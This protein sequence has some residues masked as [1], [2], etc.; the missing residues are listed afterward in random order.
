MKR[1]LTLIATLLLVVGLSACGNK[2][3]PT[4]LEETLSV[5][6]T[7]DPFSLGGIEID[8]DSS[9]Q[10]IQET[11]PATEVEVLETYS[12]GSK[13]SLYSDGSIRNTSNIDNLPEVDKLT[14]AESLMLQ[15]IVATWDEQSTLSQDYLKANIT[16]DTFPSL[17]DTD[18]QRI[19]EKIQKDKPHSSEETEAYTTEE[20][21]PATD[22]SQVYLTEEEYMQQF[23]DMS[24]EE[25]RQFIEEVT[26]GDVADPNNTVVDSEAAQK[27]QLSG[28]Q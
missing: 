2:S 6:S 23:E 24:N 14:E 25:I 10:T 4:D 18:C 7:E 20:T 19:R 16:T 22:E 21:T 13:T 17:S 11:E 8:V 5:E 26:G 1:A 9:Q 15:T 28:G 27:V 12:D 3:E